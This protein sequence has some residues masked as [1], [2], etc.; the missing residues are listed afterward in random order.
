[1]RETEPIDL[2]KQEF[3]LVEKYANEHGLSVELATAHLARRAIEARYILPKNRSN[4]VPLRGPHRGT[5]D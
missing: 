4:V 3:E 1:M 5:H 2:T